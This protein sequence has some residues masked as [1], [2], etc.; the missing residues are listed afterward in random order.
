M[1]SDFLSG[2]PKG[3]PGAPKGHPLDQWVMD[4]LEVVQRKIGAR[5]ALRAPGKVVKGCKQMWARNILPVRPPRVDADVK[6]AKSGFDEIRSNQ[7]QVQALSAQ[8]AFQSRAA[9]HLPCHIDC[10]SLS[11]L[12][13]AIH[14]TLGEKQARKGAFSENEKASLMSLNQHRR[15]LYANPGMKTAQVGAG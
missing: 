8:Q 10:T 2:Q 9:P 11:N 14:H 15:R 12:K 7:S 6:S 1:S 4:K 5:E 13:V 3:L